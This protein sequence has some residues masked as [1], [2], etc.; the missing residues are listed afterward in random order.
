[1]VAQINIVKFITS[2]MG[3][4]RSSLLHKI[5]NDCYVSVIGKICRQET[6]VTSIQRFSQKFARVD[7]GFCCQI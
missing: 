2:A 5:Y 4:A 6:N 3:V 1:M 7:P